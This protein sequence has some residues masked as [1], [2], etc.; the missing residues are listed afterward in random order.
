MKEHY[1]NLKYLV[2]DSSLYDYI[3]IDSSGIE[4]FASP[5]DKANQL[6]E[7]KIYR[8]EVKRIG[9][10]LENMHPDSATTFYRKKG[11][12]KLTEML[13]SEIYTFQRVKKLTNNQLPLKGW[14][15]ALDPGHIEASMEMAMIEAKFIRMRASEATQNQ[16]IAFNEANLTLATAL[17]LKQKLEEKGAIVMI[18]RPKAGL[19]LRDMTYQE[20]C[21][22]LMMPTIEAE[23][24]AGRLDSARAHFWRTE[25]PLSEMYR[26][27]YVPYDLRLRAEK[28]NA[29][30]PDLTLMIH[31]NVHG[32]NWEKR[33]SEDY[34]S[35]TETNYSMTFV[36]GSFMKGEL[37][38]QEDRAAFMRLLLTK[39]LPNSIRFSG[40]V[41]KKYAEIIKVPAVTAADSLLYLERSSILAEEAGVYARNLNLTR[42]IG[43][44]LCYGEA[45]CQDN[46]KECVA[47]NKKDVPLVELSTNERVKEVATAYF[48]AI[49][50][51]VKKAK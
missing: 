46:I 16:E 17:I 11:V 38:M 20:W 2:K 41:M 7:M 40:E 12:R 26:R 50:A 25:A 48:E 21:N 31:Y 6:V 30:H 45:L 49:M 47:L 15:I 27:L 35:P 37:V 42:T 22:Y 28:I 4:F 24:A 44:V 8:N 34:C 51:Y 14:R 39:D 32:P 18:T 10:L 3:R 43:G 1:P 9:E 36:G 19:N 23:V 29:F 13:P 5:E 33:D